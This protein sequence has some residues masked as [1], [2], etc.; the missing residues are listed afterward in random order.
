MVS[1]SIEML[2]RVQPASVYMSLADKIRACD[3]TQSPPRGISM[4]TLLYFCCR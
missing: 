4:H 3:G 2:F 1:R